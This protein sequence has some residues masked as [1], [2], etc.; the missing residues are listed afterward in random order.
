MNYP[1]TITMKKSGK[2]TRKAEA[3]A[4]P[5]L[6]RLAAWIMKNWKEGFSFKL[7]PSKA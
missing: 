3:V 5:A 4:A 2:R 1:V 7:T 6:R